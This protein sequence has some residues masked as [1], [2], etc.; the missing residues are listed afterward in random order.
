MLRPIEHVLRASELLH[1]EVRQAVRVRLRIPG[2][3]RPLQHALE[4]APVVGA[5]L[6]AAGREQAERIAAAGQERQHTPL[7]VE[8]KIGKITPP[9]LGMGDG[10]GA[11]VAGRLDD[12]GV[13]PMHLLSGV[14]RADD[15]PAGDD[16]GGRPPESGK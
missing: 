8:G 5:D 16:L 4:V 11:P 10:I 13:E 7:V 2:H 14:T 1:A 6:L 9:R 3:R 12:E 15:L